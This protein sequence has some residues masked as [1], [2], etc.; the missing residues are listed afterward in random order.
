[1]WL[2][3]VAF[4][5]KITLTALALF[6]SIGSFLGFPNDTLLSGMFWAVVCLMLVLGVIDHVIQNRQP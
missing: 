5:L 1:M 4:P 3:E 6:L 2:K